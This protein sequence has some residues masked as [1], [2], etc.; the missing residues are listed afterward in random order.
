[1]EGFRAHA[2][3]TSARRGDAR[4]IGIVLGTRSKR[5]RRNQSAALLDYGFR[6]K[7]DPGLARNA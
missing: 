3:C 2:F 4:L 1:M 5:A 6:H 7:E